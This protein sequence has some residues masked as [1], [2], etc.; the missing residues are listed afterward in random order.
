MDS[1]RRM[2]PV[3][4]AF[5]I[6]DATLA[7]TAPVGETLPVREAR[8]RVVLADQKSRVDLPAFDK[9]AMDGYAVLADDERD[10]YRLLETIPAGH[11]GQSELVLGAAIK[12]MTGA[13]VPKRSA[14]VI[15]VEDT[16]ER[17]GIVTVR[18]HRKSSNICT[19]GEDVRVGD[20]VLTA[21]TAL[22][23]LDIANLIACGITQV[24]VAKPLRAAIISTGDEIV[25]S[26][27][28]LA[29][30]KIMNS[31]GPMLAELSTQFGMTVVSEQTV[32]DDK[33]ATERALRKAIESA[34]IVMLSGG[35]SVGD[36]D[37][38]LD[39]FS[40]LGL[41]I[42]FSRLAAKPG[43]PTVFATAPGKVV[44]GLPGNP[45]SVFLMFHLFVVRAAALMATRSI[46]TRE[47]RLR[48]A[49]DLK[50]KSAER[51]SYIPARLTPSGE[52]E[53]VSYHGSAHLSALTRADGFAIVPVGITELPAGAEVGFVPIPRGAQW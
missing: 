23:P 41:T 9:S 28:E 21:G 47:F 24:E 1:L 49:S 25:D 31:N 44:F 5:S 35:V 37:F 53:P 17:D 27:D 12:V 26:P 20:V 34:D 43:K 15:M 46:D 6:L 30:G 36:F 51:R 14:R 48:L 11:V 22:G 29:P 19:Q 10:T 45:V 42:H 40:E 52:V 2:M 3:D 39:T 4:E 38:V 18:K 8:G 32:S 16:E 7:R 33:Q 50:R 13:A